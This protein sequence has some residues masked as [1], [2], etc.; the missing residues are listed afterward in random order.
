MI[1][2]N[3]INVIFLAFFTIQERRWDKLYLDNTE[4]AVFARNPSISVRKRRKRARNEC[5]S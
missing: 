5:Q 2:I 4:L 3:H 1:Q